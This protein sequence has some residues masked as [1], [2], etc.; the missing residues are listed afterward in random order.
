MTA[1][2][3]TRTRAAAAVVAAG[4]AA[5]AA[6]GG[7]DAPEPADV[8]DAPE[9]PD[10]GEGGDTRAQTSVVYVDLAVD[11]VVSVRDPEEDQ[12]RVEL[13]VVESEREGEARRAL[14]VFPGACG[15]ASVGLPEPGLPRPA[16]V[17]VD[18][19]GGPRASRV[20]VLEEADEIVAV[21]AWIEDAG[22][23]ASGD[24]PLPDYDAIERWEIAEGAD[25]RVGVPDP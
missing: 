3:G 4:V 8:A 19:T 13:V 7:A 11:E 18:C 24:A 16:I 14:G 10:A 1:F 12:S 17:G 21:R 22:D 20:R 15:E 25:V 2:P 6:C 9:D 23:D 5:V